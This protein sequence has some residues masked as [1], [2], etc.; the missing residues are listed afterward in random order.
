MVAFDVVRPDR[1]VGGGEAIDRLEAHV[2]S[3][4]GGRVRDFRVA[5]RDGGLVLCGRTRTYH[6]KQLAQHEVTRASGLPVLA[7]RIEVACLTRDG[8]SRTDGAE[9]GRPEAD[10]PRRL[11][12]VATGDDR[13][14]S[15]ARGYLA[16]HGF[17]IATAADGVECVAVIRELDSAVDVA[18][19]DA[20]LLW[21]GAAGVIEHLRTSTGKPAAVVLLT[22]QPVGTHPPGTSIAPPVVSVIGK[23]VRMGA[24]LWA[25]QS[26]AREGPATSHEP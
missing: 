17:A 23:P 13:L 18:V 8:E 3:R 11:V 7:N 12:L 24:L 10:P 1:P 2:R 25:V 19:L 6:E 5:A 16:E 14:R 20:D 22:S 9:S 4:L 15:A 21:G 26:A